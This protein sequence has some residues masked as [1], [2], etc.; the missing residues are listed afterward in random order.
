MHSVKLYLGNERTR[1][2]VSGT[3]NARYYIDMHK[4]IYKEV[5][6]M[7]YILTKYRKRISKS[8]AYLVI[9]PYYTPHTY[10]TPAKISPSY[11]Y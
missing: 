6:G 8:G 4:D 11:T 7:F 5:W 3:F 1:P 9:D 2:R 10:Y